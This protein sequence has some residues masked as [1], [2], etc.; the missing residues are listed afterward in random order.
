MADVVT[1]CAA[2]TLIHTGKGQ[3]VGLIAT[4]NSTTA[5]ILTL[6]DNT[7]G[8]GTKLLEFYVALDRA[9]ILFFDERYYLNYATGLYLMMS[10]AVPVTVWS[11]QL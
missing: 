3:V 1:V 9:L 2:A 5:A 8:S 6:Y 10:A 4:Y 7:A 11:R